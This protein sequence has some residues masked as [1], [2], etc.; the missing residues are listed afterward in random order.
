MR[1][2]FINEREE[3]GGREDY[4][5]NIR[6]LLQEAGHV[7][8]LV[9]AK[10]RSRPPLAQGDISFLVP[11]LDSREDTSATLSRIQECQALFKADVIH[12]HYQP[13]NLSVTRWLLKSFPVLRS[14][15]DVDFLCPI[16]YYVRADTGQACNEK[17]GAICFSAGCLEAWNP[18]GPVRLFRTKRNQRL[19]SRQSQLN[20]Q[21]PYM[22]ERIEQALGGKVKVGVI[23]VSAPPIEPY[24]P[25]QNDRHFIFVGRLHQTKGPQI[26]IEAMQSLPADSTLDIVGTGNMEPA[27]RADVKRLGLEERVRFSG[28][29]RGDDLR[30]K[31]NEAAALVFPAI[32]PENCPLVVQ[33]A[34]AYGRPVVA[35]RTGGIPDLVTDGVEGFLMPAPDPRACADAM[36][37]LLDDPE[38][39]REMGRRGIARMSEE[40]FSTAWHLRMLTEEYEAAISSFNQRSSARPR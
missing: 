16:R 3:H 15:H 13:A 26:A 12:L 22:R 5:S 25:P 38:G 32:Q 11:G 20:T 18:R 34:M 14:I 8:G 36:K 23:P 29:L 19:F 33:E 35:T 17:C 6:R 31:F 4:I 1:I 10:P 28:Y 9:H 21:S 30:R 2:L 39:A 24:Q 37:R 27:L 7:T 40:R